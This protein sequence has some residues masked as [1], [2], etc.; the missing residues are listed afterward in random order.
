VSNPQPISI[1]GDINYLAKFADGELVSIRNDNPELIKD[2]DRERPARTVSLRRSS[3][4][5]Q[6]WSEPS[7]AF[8]Y[9]AGTGF[10]MPVASVVDHADRLHVFGLRFLNLSWGDGPN[11]SELLHTWSDD[12]GDSW[13]GT[14]AIDY[15][16]NYTG[17]INNVTVLG[18]GRILLPLSY[19]DPDRDSGKF[20]SKTVFSDDGG[21]TWGYSNGCPIVGGG[22]FPESGSMEPVVVELN[23]GLVWM[24]IRTVS[25]YF[26]ES[27]SNDGS[28]WTP[29]KPTRIVS[30]NAPAGV[31]RL[32]SGEIV[33]AWNNRY[34]EPMREHGISYARQKL[35]IAL[36]R[37]D[38]QTW[39]VPKEIASISDDDPN[40]DQTTYP[41]LFEAADGSL[42]VVYHRIQKDNGRSWHNPIR[43]LIRID[44]AWISRA[45]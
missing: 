1:E 32:Q 40:Y 8:A 27:F 15:G 19:L 33:M 20:V 38:A 29:P 3:D 25:G 41:Y 37:D 18:T 10:S 21:E 11:H 26:W 39:S 30:C 36:S 2:L 12:R 4:H 44:P 17:S 16:Q 7:V 42:L 14:N 9:P 35:Y 22:D 5:G 28:I 13:S 31:V 45:G 34:G 43:E 6:T 24:V 23:S